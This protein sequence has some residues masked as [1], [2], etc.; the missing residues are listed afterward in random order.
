MKKKNLIIVCLITFAV[1]AFS[2]SAARQSESHIIDN[3]YVTPH[4]KWALPLE[5]EPLKV[6]FISPATGSRDIWDLAQRISIDHTVF[7]LQPG[8]AGRFGLPDM[9][10]K[11]PVVYSQ[12]QEKL[13]EILDAA[14]FDLIVLANV[15]WSTIPMDIV[16][17]I[18]A[19]AVR[20]GAGIIVTN[21]DFKDEMLEQL[22]TQEFLGDGMELFQPFPFEALERGLTEREFKQLGADVSP[23]KLLDTSVPYHQPGNRKFDMQGK[24]RG[25]QLK[26]GK[27]LS[28]Q[29]PFEGVSW[30]AWGCVPS[31]IP[32]IP[33]NMRNLWQEEYYYMLLAKAFLWTA[34]RNPSAKLTAISPMN[35]ELRTGTPLEISLELRT[36]EK[37]ASFDGR[38]VVD[39]RDAVTGRYIGKA[40]KQ[41]SFDDKASI[42]LEVTQVDEPE[43]PLL[44]A[45]NAFMQVRLYKQVKQ[46]L[47]K[48][49]DVVVDFGAGFVRATTDRP[50]V[51]DLDKD[52]FEFPEPV[53]MQITVP[54]NDGIDSFAFELYD[55]RGR[56][57][58]KAETK[59]TGKNV[60]VSLPTARTQLLAHGV[61]VIAY[62]DEKPVDVKDAFFTVRRTKNPG[63]YYVLIAD[64]MWPTWHSLRRLERAYEWG[65]DGV[66]NHKA[67]VA[68][69][70]TTAIAGLDTNPGRPHVPHTLALDP[71]KVDEL[72]TAGREQSAIYRLFNQK[73]YNT[74]DDCGPEVRNV[75]TP[76]VP[77]FIDWLKKEHEGEIEKLNDQWET[78]FAGFDDITPAFVQKSA[79]EGCIPAWVDYCRFVNAK[80]IEAQNRY[81]KAIREIDPQVASGTDAVYYGHS[82]ASLY[83]NVSYIMPYYRPTVV[84]MARSLAKAKPPV[85]TGICMGYGTHLPKPFHTYLPWHI[86]LAGNNS[87]LYW[88][89]SAGLYGDLVYGDTPGG[90]RPGWMMQEVANIKLTGLGSFI[91]K[92]KRISSGIAILYSEASRRAQDGDAPFSRLDGRVSPAALS[93]QELLSDHGLSYDYISSACITEDAALE[94]DRIKLLILPQVQSLSVAEAEKI[95]RFVREG[96]TLLADVRPGVRTERGKRLEKGLLDD[97]FGI[98]R[99]KDAV[100]DLKV[101][102]PQT[103]IPVDIK[104]DAAVS[105]VQAEPLLVKD[106]IPLFISNNYGRGKTLLMNFDATFMSVSTRGDAES[107]STARQSTP[108][109]ASFDFIRK[110]FHNLGV[111]PLHEAQLDGEAPLG[112]KRTLLQNQDAQVLALEIKPITGYEYPRTLTLDLA[113]EYHLVE[114]RSGKKYGQRKELS[115]EVEPYDVLL[116]SLMDEKPSGLDMKAPSRIAAGETMKIEV[117]R[118]NAP[119]AGTLQFKLTNPE[120]GFLRD[121]QSVSAANGDT[122]AGTIQLPYNSIP[123]AWMLEVVDWITGQRATQTIQVR[124]AR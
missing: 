27:F 58:E 6:L 94:N 34:G 79:K 15:A 14:R 1:T 33:V 9:F 45:S 100:T 124:G 19:Q 5:G 3:E 17:K 40:V 21:A 97:V 2:V 122:V 50:L 52:V 54:D 24:I 81:N 117:L 16:Y 68:D 39:V 67:N 120:G 32:G 18:T 93:F 91:N 103:D 61:R 83:R 60:T 37:N 23:V 90:Y 108:A 25:Y 11:D 20:G 102:F 98:S 82:L 107:A 114:I 38:I 75:H 76:A 85:F 110:I 123:G 121:Y 28:V 96:G 80:Y 89:L 35:E 43:K 109:L 55:S 22:Y 62:A 92:S 26:R 71:A 13:N 7:E 36:S 66:R 118:K 41:V 72:E 95:T 116:F 51:V 31:L 4:F 111:N 105:L 64:E 57:W 99:D 78:A 46:G 119:A 48:K 84:E 10:A 104:A 44:L 73:L 49:K 101:V 12:R 106:N 65:A 53:K 8:A 47:L 115:L 112:V 30:A 63:D 88:S 59:V 42:S 86:L 70:I 77:Y 74:T 87:I 113:G 29:F 56:V 69:A